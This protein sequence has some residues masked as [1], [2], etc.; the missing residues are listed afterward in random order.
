MTATVAVARAPRLRLTRRG[1]VVFTSLAAVPVVIA[2]MVF[3]LNGG[4]AVATD[5]AGSLETVTV[6]AGQTMWD[7]AEEV[8]PTADPRDVIAEFLAVNQLGSSGLQPG[9]QLAVPARYSD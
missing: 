3:A 6:S 7:L 4:G 9:Q 5:G 2:A 8:A 1:R